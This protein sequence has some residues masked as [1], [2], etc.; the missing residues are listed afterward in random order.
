MRR[1]YDDPR[2]ARA[3]AFERPPLHRPILERIGDG[4][5]ITVPVRWALDIG[6]GA[7]LSTA[8]LGPF[9]ERAAGIDPSTIMLAHG[10]ALA[11]NAVFL[12]GEAERLPFAAGTFELITAAGSINYTDLR[13]SLPEAARVLAPVGAMVI[14]DFSPGR[15]VR[16]SRRLGD[17]YQEFERRYPRP[18]GY[19]LDVRC[20]DC[21]HTGLRLD[22]YEELEIQIAMSLDAYLRYVMTETR[23]ALAI[24]D[25]VQDSE[26]R[27]WSR[28][29]LRDVFEDQSR[30]VVFD[31][32]VAY[33]RRHGPA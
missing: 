2:V 19:D 1:S 26:I 15:R 22:G 23:V 33:L 6:C 12:A 20:L 10:P 31:A 14:Y 9:A 3:Y 32:Y 18:P 7:G 16:A 17:W 27:D 30:D 8:A 13:R 28:E 29:T 21:A 4:L 25:G 24:R 11:P 5:G